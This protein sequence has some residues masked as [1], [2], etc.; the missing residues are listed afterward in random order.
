M[1]FAKF[2]LSLLAISFGIV[3]PAIA[4]AGFSVT[5]GAQ[6]NITG[7]SDVSLIGNLVYAYK[8]V[9]TAIGDTT[10]NGVAFSEFV[11]PDNESSV[12]VGAVR[13]SESVGFLK[14]SGFYD[15]SNNPFSNLSTG[16]QQLL[17]YAVTATAPST[18]TLQ[19]GLLTI[20]HTYD[21]QWW[22]NNSTTDSGWNDTTATATNSVT[23]IS[24]SGFLNAPF[25]PVE[26]GLGQY[27]IGR[28]TATNTTHL[29]NFNGTSVFPLINAFQ[30][31]S[32]SL[33]VPEPSML[34]IAVSGFA[35]GTF[36]KRK[37]I[38]RLRRSCATEGH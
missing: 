14:G 12:D 18:I 26:G 30:L 20:G 28:F 2:A 21:F 5:W 33:V 3:S 24:N 35:F 29:I 17:R 36:S 25:S 8:F 6:K 34:V 1:R 4:G 32:V 19:L 31:R 15:S 7:D 27:A 13:I 23:L 38:F 37:Q 22:S 9:P 16:Y 10:V 11:V